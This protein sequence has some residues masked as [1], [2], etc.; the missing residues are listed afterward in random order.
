[1]IPVFTASYEVLSDH[2][3][4]LGHVNNLVYLDWA[5]RSAV[6]HSAINGWPYSRYEKE[7]AGWVVRTH[8]IT[9]FRPAFIGETVRVRTWIAELK[10]ATCQRRYRLE[11]LDAEKPMLLAEAATDWAFIDFGRQLPKR[12]P[13]ELIDSFAV[14]PEGPPE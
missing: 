5:V 11:R 14:L 13:Q 2:I 7:G 6:E 8:T 4:Q 12:I 1:M 10:R 3:D 9:Y